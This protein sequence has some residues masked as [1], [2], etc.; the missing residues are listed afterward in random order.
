[1]TL[2]P[3]D[4]ASP[5]PDAIAL[6]AA[7]LAAGQLVVV[8]TDSVYGLAADP[9]LPG[10]VSRLFE[11]KGRP[12]TLAIPV[13]VA[14]LAQVARLVRL[15]ERARRAIGAHWPGA[16]TL[17]LPRREGVTWDL[18]DRPGTLAVRMPDHPVALELLTQAGPLAVTSA[19]PT[20]EPTPD[21]AG[22]VR[23][24][25]GDA[26]S[27]Y[28]DAGPSPGGTPSTVLDL[29]GPEAVVLRAGALPAEDVRAALG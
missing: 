19:N 7:A 1:M 14:S 6:A 23:D 27:V 20:G 3:V 25:L 21:T 13:L 8:P 28:L 17:V 22:E 4:P 9:S 5:D 29:S 11:A 10:A 26:V 24:L 18:G 12:R 15:D 2:L 16:L